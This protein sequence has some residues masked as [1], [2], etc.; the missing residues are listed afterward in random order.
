MASAL[1][2]SMSLAA[3]NRNES[4]GEREDELELENESEGES[5]SDDD[6]WDSLDDDDRAFD[7]DD[8]TAQKDVPGVLVAGKGVVRCNW[9]DAVDNDGHPASKKA[10]VDSDEEAAFT[11]L[12]DGASTTERFQ[13]KGPSCRFTER[14]QLEGPSCRY[15]EC[16]AGDLRHS[17]IAKAIRTSLVNRLTVLRIDNF[18]GA[19]DPVFGTRHELRRRFRAP[20]LFA[21]LTGAFAGGARCGLKQLT[22]QG[23]FMSAESLMSF[24][25]VAKPPLES[26]RCRRCLF[27]GRNFEAIVSSLRSSIE[28]AGDL[29]E[30]ETDACIGGLDPFGLIAASFPNLRVLR[31]RRIF[32]KTDRRAAIQALPQLQIKKCRFPKDSHKLRGRPAVGK[33]GLVYWF[34]TSDYHDDGY[35]GQGLWWDGL[36][37]TCECMEEWSVG[38][39]VTKQQCLEFMEECG[40][41]LDEDLDDE[42]CGMMSDSGEVPEDEEDTIVA[43]LDVNALSS[44]EV[45]IKAATMQGRIFAEVSLDPNKTLISTLFQELAPKYPCSC[46][47]LRL[48]LPDS[49]SVD[50]LVQGSKT[51]ASILE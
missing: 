40:I 43:Q 22:L 37:N 19:G 17:L 29:H 38:R 47:A 15:G 7:F 46:E 12:Q 33:K 50:V 27:H 20:D 8:H 28:D 13:L 51:L 9:S 21:G 11:E 25:Q 4:T 1:A 30:F 2:T 39:G 24:L 49:S 26:F 18:P 44:E 5:Q 42:D 6:R 36:D 14:F 31:A 32:G 41:D 48:V 16:R 3:A 34:I 45:V 23:G 35:R 10:K